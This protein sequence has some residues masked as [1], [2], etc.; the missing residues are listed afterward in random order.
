MGID[1][2]AGSVEYC[3]RIGP[4]RDLLRAKFGESEV[5]LPGVNSEETSF[6]WV[7]NCTQIPLTWCSITLKRDVA[8]NKETTAVC[9]G[10]WEAGASRCRTRH[11]YGQAPCLYR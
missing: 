7:L 1:P 3:V 11:P 2:H 5:Q 10:C 6:H 9:Q 8:N 4:G